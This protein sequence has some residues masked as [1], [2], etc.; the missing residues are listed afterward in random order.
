MAQ[1][2]V[3]AASISQV[4]GSGRKNQDS[5]P[6]SAKAVSSLCSARP[7]DRSKSSHPDF[8][9]L[10]PINIKSEAAFP[11][12]G[13]ALTAASGGIHWMDYEVSANHQ[14]RAN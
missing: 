8:D 12:S 7:C 10:P 3:P 9:Y 2:Q 6:F 11:E 13:I 1:S 5:N 4:A 14:R